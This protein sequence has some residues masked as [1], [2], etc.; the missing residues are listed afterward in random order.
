[1]GYGK[2]KK[3]LSKKLLRA[4]NDQI[5]KEIYSA[6]LYYSMEAYDKAEPLYHEALR[7]QKHMQDDWR[8]PAVFSY[9]YE[10]GSCKQGLWFFVSND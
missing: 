5:N 6:Y 10:T 2:E 4:M 3:M 1:M 9:V 7:I 8:S